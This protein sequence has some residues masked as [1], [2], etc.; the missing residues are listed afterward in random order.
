MFLVYFSSPPLVQSPLFSC[1]IVDGDR[2]VR[3]ATIL[4][5]WCERNWREYKIPMGTG[6]GVI[7]PPAVPSIDRIHVHLVL[8]PLSLASRDQGGGSW[9]QRSASTISRKKRGLR[10]VYLTLSIFL[11]YNQATLGVTFIKMGTFTQLVACSLLASLSFY[12]TVTSTPTAKQVIFRLFVCLLL[13]FFNKEQMDFCLFSFCL[14][15]DKGVVR[16]NE[17]TVLSEYT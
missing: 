7:F 1:E 3:L 5:P 4:V 12:R 11:Y 17:G 13:F 16:N 10:T 15:H 14:S 8:S 2:W 9:T 6:G